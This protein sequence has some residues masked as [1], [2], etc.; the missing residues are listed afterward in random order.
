M[1][2]KHIEHRTYVEFL[3]RVNVSVHTCISTV[4]YIMLGEEK[5]VTRGGE[6]WTINP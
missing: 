4:K 2:T 3:R 1:N 6:E 5:T